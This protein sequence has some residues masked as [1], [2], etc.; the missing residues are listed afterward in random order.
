M[1]KLVGKS[2]C[3]KSGNGLQCTDMLEQSKARM[4]L[5]NTPISYTETRN[6]IGNA[7]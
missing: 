7:V 4:R 2:S 3:Q 5:K 6:L 1:Q